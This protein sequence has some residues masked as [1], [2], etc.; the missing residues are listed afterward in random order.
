MA[1]SA[2]PQ[3]KWQDYFETVTLAGEATDADPFADADFGY[4]PIDMPVQIPFSDGQ[5]TEFRP[6]TDAFWTY[7]NGRLRLIVSPSIDTLYN[8]AFGFIISSRIISSGGF[9]GRNAYG[10]TARVSRA[11]VRTVG[12]EASKLPLG[13]VSPY[14]SAYS[15]PRYGNNYWVELDVGGVEAR[16]IT[17]NAY[18]EISMKAN[19]RTSAR[20]ECRTLLDTATIDRPIEATRTVCAF[21]ADVSKIA[22]KRAD[23]GETLALWPR[24]GDAAPLK[25]IGAES[26]WISSKDYPY[27]S[28]RNGE[29]GSVSVEMVIA[30]DGSAFN[31]RVVR[32]TG[33]E[34]LDRHTCR[35]LTERAKFEPFKAGGDSQKLY[36]RS[37][38]WP[39]GIIS[40][41][42]L[43]Q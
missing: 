27:S 15:E 29:T 5:T 20:P 21:A 18:V 32:G 33:H 38:N 3:S 12:V 42:S 16:A 19:S 24:T 13:E 14:R 9:V 17:R 26:A 41:P 30:P 11:I 6:D 37:V 2:S 39:S 35:L 31:C 10:A 40:D 22:I 28:G 34:S 23:T 7:D 25:P 43:S 1:S 36:T 4:P 8:R